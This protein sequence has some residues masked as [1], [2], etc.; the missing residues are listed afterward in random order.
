M[1]KPNISSRLLNGLIIVG[2]ALVSCGPV[3]TA[4]PDIGG[5][6]QG[7]VYGDL[8]SNGAIDPGEVVLEGADVTIS[9]CG[10]PQTRVTGADGLFNFIDL[11]AGTCHVSVAKTGWIFSGSYPALGYPIP[12]AS[13]PTLPTS[14]SLFLAP[15]GRAIP[16]YTPTLPAG[17]P[18]L[19]TATFT[20]ALIISPNSATP[21]ITPKSQAANC[22]FGPAVGFLAVGGLKVGI[23]VPIVST[24]AN[25][26]WWQ[27]ENPQEPDTFCWVSGTVTTTIGNTLK[28]PVVPIP[29]AQVISV[30]VTTPAVVHGFCGD[31]N[32]TSFDVTITTNGPV[33]VQWH[34]EISTSTGTV[35]NT[36]TN[37]PLIFTAAGPLSYSSDEYKRDCG[38]YIVKAL[39]TSPNAK[40]GQASWT[41]VQP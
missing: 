13:D 33:T 15:I 41:V 1:L 11:P 39:I 24:I 17:T 10:T 14:F 25:R 35:L 7:A 26:S 5:I 32:A 40:T 31:P 3:G 28:V 6:V 8:N 16:S 19:P 27:I 18:G 34:F 29:I 9:G 30:V 37:Q 36:T 38:S 22:R 21:M 4:T 20:P 2:I 23:T 12:V